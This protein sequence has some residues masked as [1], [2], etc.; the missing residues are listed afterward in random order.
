MKQQSNARLSALFLWRIWVHKF[1]LGKNRQWVAYLLL[2]RTW[3]PMIISIIESIFLYNMTTE[4]FNRKYNEGKPIEQRSFFSHRDKKLI[5]R[6]WIV[7][8]WSFS[9][10]LLLSFSWA[11]DYSEEEL[12]AMEI[13]KLEQEKIDNEKAEQ[14]A[15][16]NKQ[17]AVEQLEELKQ[18]LTNEIEGVN[19]YNTNN[20]KW[21]SVSLGITLWLLDA[22]IEVAGE[23][24]D[25]EDDEIRQLSNQLEMSISTLQ[26]KVYP[27]MRKRYSEYMDEALWEDNMEVSVKWTYSDT[28]VVVGWAFANNKNIKT[29][30]ENMR[31]TLIKLRFTNAQYR[32]IQNW[33]WTE[34]TL[35]TPE[36]KKILRSVK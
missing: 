18:R 12:A 22:L 35:E 33:E 14:L 4:K 10:L 31:D 6:V 23:N 26:S 27:I 15:I 8:W 11:L 19:S 1:Y 34:Y 17:K 21:D 3:V 7:L 32:R 20:I 36:D 24:K 28:I 30:Y 9:A 5:K 16:E 25:H 13:E 2:C 29:M